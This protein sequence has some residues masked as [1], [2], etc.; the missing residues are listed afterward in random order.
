[1]AREAKSR[2]R[3]STWSAKALFIERSSWTEDSFSALMRDR[4]REMFDIVRLQE[5][6]RVCLQ[7]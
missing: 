4:S 7:H 3:F 6:M 1:M 5:E 2:S